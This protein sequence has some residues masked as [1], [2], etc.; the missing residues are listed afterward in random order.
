MIRGSST[1]ALILRFY[2][3][4]IQINAS[5]QPDGGFFFTRWWFFLLI[6]RTV[7]RNP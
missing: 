7:F 3:V 4:E 6:T 5:R 2:C 1:A